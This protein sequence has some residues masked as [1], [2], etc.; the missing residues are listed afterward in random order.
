M[1]RNPLDRRMFTNPQQRRGMARMPQG[2]LASGPRIMNAAMEQEPV[3]RQTGGYQGPATG[4]GMSGFTDFLNEYVLGP[5][6]QIGGSPSTDESV[7]PPAASGAVVPKPT[8]KP[9]PAP[10]AGTSEFPDPDVRSTQPGDVNF[11]PELIGGAPYPQPGAVDSGTGRL[12]EP[13]PPAADDTQE[14]KPKSVFDEL[15]QILETTTPE[16]KQ[17]KTSEYVGEAKKLLEEYGIEA[18]DLKSRRDLRIMEFFLNMAAGQSPDF[19]TNVAQAGKES[20]KGY[21]EDVREV[22]SAEQKLKLASLEMGMAEE[23]RDEAAAQALLLKKYDIAADLFEKIND[24]PDK[25]QQIKV[26]METY[27]VPQE[28]AIKLVYPDKTVSPTAYA[29]SRQAFIDQGHSAGVANYLAKFGASLITM[30]D[31]NPQFGEQLGNAVLAGGQNLTG[32]DK[33]VLGLPD[34][35]GETFRAGQ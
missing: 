25:S 29:A 16:G 7:S 32:T 18:P 2:I 15:K 21:G 10:G 28:D 13:T 23:A 24:L 34:N 27:D 19:L 31:Q 26:L 14:D 9:Q 22:E 6:M 8:P 5:N 20:F 3:R 17:K 30:L 33:Q 11:G 1:M 12:V 35:F 4:L